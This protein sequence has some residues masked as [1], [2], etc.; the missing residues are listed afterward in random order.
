MS[1]NED[2]RVAS[3]K[4]DNISERIDLISEEAEQI[5]EELNEL[6][7]II[8]EALAFSHRRDKVNNN[9]EGR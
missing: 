8:D 6:K 1:K 7:R 5:G 9:N 2:L 3:E 4:V